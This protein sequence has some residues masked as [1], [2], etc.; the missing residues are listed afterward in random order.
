LLAL[1][2]FFETPNALAPHNKKR[3]A[4]NESTEI[5]RAIFIIIY[6]SHKIILNEGFFY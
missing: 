1:L 6:L 4:V 2:S 5:D 3:R